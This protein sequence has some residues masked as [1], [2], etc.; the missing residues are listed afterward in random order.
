MTAKSHAVPVAGI[1]PTILSTVP[2]WR[3]CAS[4]GETTPGTAVDAAIAC[5]GVT[6]SPTA[7]SARAPTTAS[8]SAANSRPSPG[9]SLPQRV[10]SAAVVPTSG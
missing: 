1:R 4:S 9:C 7:S 5:E 2:S 6:V 3:C 8:S 10:T